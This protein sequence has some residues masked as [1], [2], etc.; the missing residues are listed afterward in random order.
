[1]IWNL[2]EF[3]S[4]KKLHVYN[5]DILNHISMSTQ[6][7]SSMLSEGYHYNRTL[8]KTDNRKLPTVWH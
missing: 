1:M 3:E 2:L 5:N 7:L 4:L 8:L 6:R